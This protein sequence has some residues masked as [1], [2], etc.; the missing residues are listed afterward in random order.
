[1]MALSIY[2]EVEM[3]GQCSIGYN[4]LAYTCIKISWKMMKSTLSITESHCCYTCVNNHN[5]VTVCNTYIQYFYMYKIINAT[6]PE[7]LCTDWF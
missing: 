5:K 2:N 6:E 4:I 7:Q 1:M 3:N